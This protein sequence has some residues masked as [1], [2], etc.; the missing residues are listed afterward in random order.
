M[1]AGLHTMQR[2]MLSDDPLVVAARSLGTQ[3]MRSTKLLQLFIDPPGV[4]QA[5]RL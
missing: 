3:A 2:L 4:P 1:A 5:C